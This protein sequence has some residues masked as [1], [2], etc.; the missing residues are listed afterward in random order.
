MSFITDNSTQLSLTQAQA[1]VIFNNNKG[2]TEYITSN[3]LGNVLTPY[4]S[5]N[6]LTNVSSFYISSNV[7][8]NVLIPYKP[9]WK[10]STITPTEQNYYYNAG[11]IG[12]GVLDSSTINTKLKVIGET[13]LNGIYIDGDSIYKKTNEGLLRF[14][15]VNNDI[16]FNT[17]LNERMRIFEGGSLG[18]NTIT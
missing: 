13:N 7:L 17:N 1:N 11:N 18:I 6:V 3:V 10:Y 8:T 5:S 2:S 14:S 15:V 12:I 16:I 9:I 4:V